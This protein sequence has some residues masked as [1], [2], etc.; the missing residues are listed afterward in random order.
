[1]TAAVAPGAELHGLLPWYRRSGR[2][3]L[4]WRLTRDP[5]AVVV[6]E[7]MLQQTQVERVLPYYRAWL[8]RWPAFAQLATAGPADVIRAWSGLGYNRR[9]VN[10][11]RMAD[12]VVARYGGQL[13]A[14][15][16]GLRRLPGI[17]VYTAGAVRSFA[18]HEPVAVVD[19]NVARVI[20]RGMF[21]VAGARDLSPATLR[22]A[23]GAALPR[24]GVRDHN[25][26][27]MDLGALVCR[28][29]APQCQDCP[30]RAR[31]R[32]RAAGY[33]AGRAS[34]V[35]APRFEE[36]TRFARGRI[37]DALRAEDQLSA[38]QIAALLPGRHAASVDRYLEALERE[39]LVVRAAG[40]AWSLP[41]RIQGSTSMASP[42]L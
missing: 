25:L 34:G 38:G 32:W 37:V 8:E 13:P 39:Q 7:V 1:V 12:E 28:S 10:L 41:G 31:C 24:R 5:Y 35:K 11:H 20:A 21:G 9:A 23:A 29:R 16:A 40:G 3:E 17:G 36:T 6:S 27:L 15:E 26:A 14:T 4:P 2:H 30:L 18:R 19:T 42:K 22:A 33:P